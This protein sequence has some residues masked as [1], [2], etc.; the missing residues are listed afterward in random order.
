MEAQIRG[1]HR[2]GENIQDGIS[3]IQTAE[4][5]LAQIQNP[6]LQRVRELII[7]AANETN[8]PEDRALAL[9]QKEIDQIV[10]GIDDIADDTEF[11]TMPVLT[12]DREMEN[13]IRQNKFDI[14][15]LIDDSGTMSEEINSVRLGLGTFIQNMGQYGD[16]NVGTISVVH[17]N[18]DLALTG[19][20]NKVI[21]HLNTMHSADG[22]ST[23]TYDHLDGLLNGSNNVV[24]FRS[25]TTAK[26]SLSSL[27]ILAMR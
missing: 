10:Q 22:G 13:Q 3:L 6:N 18:R 23:S 16:V 4:G 20:V 21:N 2:A 19:D 9:I 7:Q 1:L 11:N 26:R 27:P 5:G 15:F 24:N 25:D 12:P 17:N 8:T 14:V